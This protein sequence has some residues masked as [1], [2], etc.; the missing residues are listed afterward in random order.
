MRR[1]RDPDPKGV[2]LPKK[3]HLQDAELPHGYKKPRAR[4]GRRTTYDTGVV[5][6]ELRLLVK[7]GRGARG[8]VIWSVQCLR[9][10]RVYARTNVAGHRCEGSGPCSRCAHPGRGKPKVCLCGEKDP[11]RFKERVSECRTC[12]RRAM[13][14]GRCSCGRAKFRSKGCACEP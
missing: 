10:R 5:I 9:C 4:A 6:G 14:N 11:A 13:R 3:W 8:I 7:L 12:N 2:W 1:Q